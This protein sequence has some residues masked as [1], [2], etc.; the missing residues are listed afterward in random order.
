ML[1][2]LQQ[3]NMFQFECKLKMNEAMKKYA[4]GVTRGMQ[5]SHY[6]ERYFEVQGMQTLTYY[7]AFW[8][9]FNKQLTCLLSYSQKQFKRWLSLKQLT[10]TLKPLS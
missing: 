6:V 9:V 5:V 8:D 4:V 2:E 7:N 3:E 10:P 1:G